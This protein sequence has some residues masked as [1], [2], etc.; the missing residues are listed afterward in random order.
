VLRYLKETLN[1]IIAMVYF[2]YLKLTNKKHHRLVIYY[3]G[4][5]VVDIASFRRQMECLARSFT[6]VK[7]SEIITADRDGANNLIAITF[8]DAFVSVMENAVPILKKYGLPAG[9]FVPVGN[10]GQKPDWKI[11]E[12]FPDKNEVVMSK[13]QIRQLDKEGLEIFSHT[14]SHPVLTEIE[15]DRL[16]AELV[17]S[18]QNLERIIGHEVIG[19]SYP[20]GVCDSRVCNA[21][22]R[23]GYRFGFTIAPGMVVS[24]TDNL[25]IGR[26]TVSP[27]DSLL[28]FKLKVKGAYQEVK[29]VRV[30]KKILLRSIGR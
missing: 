12:N 9:I 6:V 16:E 25:A 5:N 28:K 21:V 24:S 30:L 27:Y 26:F 20:H 14:L 13:E 15:D 7:P 22:K 4:L 23:A 1:L 2:A 10:L 3:H 18:K 17:G 8:D 11:P 19:I 29:L